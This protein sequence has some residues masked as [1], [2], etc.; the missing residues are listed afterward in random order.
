MA[1]GGPRNR[2]GPSL[3]PNSAT[4][5]KRGIVLTALP[6]EGYTGKAPEY[7]LPKMLIKEWVQEDKR[8]WRQFDEDSTVAFR[9]RELDLWQSVWRYPQACA[10]ALEPWR[11]NVIAMWVRTFVVCEGDDATA[12]DKSALHRFADQIGMTP[13]GLKE[14]GWRIAKDD[15]G[16]KRQA[17]APAGKS[18]RQ[19][20]TVVRDGTEG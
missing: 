5:D 18:S 11:W 19:R 7:P 6:A 9:E 4:S 17:K 20:M 15:V 12:A 8:R 2:S 3:D 14:N 16:E 10:W 1:S 13:A